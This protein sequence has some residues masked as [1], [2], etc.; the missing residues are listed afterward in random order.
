MCYVKHA[1]SLNY[2]WGTY[3]LYNWQHVSCCWKGLF[4]RLIPLGL[5]VIHYITSFPVSGHDHRVSC[6]T[7]TQKFEINLS[8]KDKSIK[9]A[10]NMHVILRETPL[11]LFTVKFE[12]YTANSIGNMGQNGCVFHVTRTCGHIFEL[13]FWI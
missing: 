1:K 4:S 12:L 13:S 7:I 6:N 10:S 2:S 5:C 9:I 11:E 3:K 8:I